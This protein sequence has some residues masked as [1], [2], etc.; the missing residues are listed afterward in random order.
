MG[1]SGRFGEK[2]LASVM[3]FSKH[4]LTVKCQQ[5]RHMME[6]GDRGG[7]GLKMGLSVLEE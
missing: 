3:Q 2:S 1:R 7:R 5:G 6:E 4:V